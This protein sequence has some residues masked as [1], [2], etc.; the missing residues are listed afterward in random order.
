MNTKNPIRT[1]VV[2]TLLSASL[3]LFSTVLYA[4]DTDGD[5]VDDAIDNCPAI[6]NADQLNSDTASFASTAGWSSSNGFGACSGLYTSTPCM[7]GTNLI[8]SYVTSRVSRSITVLNPA[9]IQMSVNVRGNPSGSSSYDSGSVTLNA[10]DTNNKLLDTSNWS[11]DILDGNVQTI[12]LSLSNTA[13]FPQVTRVEIIFTGRD[14]GLWGGNYGSVFSALAP[15][16]GDSEGDV[17]DTD[18]DNDTVADVTDNCPLVANSNQL[19]WDS[20]GNGDQCDDPVP[21][22]ADSEGT[23]KADKRGTAVAFA[24]DFNGDGY[25]DYV[26]GTPNFD[27]PLPAPSKKKLANAGRVEVISGRNG[28]VITSLNGVVAKDALGYA[29][30]GGK[31]I[32]NDGFDDVVVSAPY[33]DN[34]PAKDVGAF[35]VLYGSA[36]DS[37]PPSAAFFGTEAKAIFGAA[38]AL[39]D[40]NN[41]STPDVIV[42][43]PKAKDVDNN[44]AQA[45]KVQVFDGSNLSNVLRTIYG[46][47]AKANAGTAVA[48]ANVDGNAGDEVIVG[49]PLDDNTNPLALLNDAGSVAVYAF[50]QTSSVWTVHGTT[51]GSRFGQAIAAG[52]VTGSAVAEVLVGAPKDDDTDNSRKD[53]GSITLLASADGTTLVTRYGANAKAELGTSVA[54]GD[55]DGDGTPDL[56]A[57]APK[58][59][60]PT[61]PKVTKDTGSISVWNGAGYAPM[62]SVY[63]AVKKDYFGTAISAGDINRDNKADIIVG[64]PGFDAPIPESTK[65]IKDAG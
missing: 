45:G 28:L 46:T 56:V 41:D 50:G 44:L 4:A 1:S 55:V 9:T 60:S 37:R 65:T 21:T 27:V 42:G 14:L 52:D 3:L 17:C 43:S 57:G 32:D 12:N 34:L 13:V 5:G 8:F 40:F 20:D 10:Y 49:A 36:D 6:A 48:A 39:G 51:K 22:P 23:A 7:D 11:S 29:V 64:I 59:D 24:G 16:G 31:D 30:A 62:P 25:G 58:D 61:S 15:P 38:L 63:G 54:L 35:Y 26:V 47:T 2:R 18:D 33:A 53:A 19:D